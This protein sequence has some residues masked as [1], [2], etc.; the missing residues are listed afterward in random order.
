MDIQIQNNFTPILLLLTGIYFIFLALTTLSVKAK[1]LEKVLES[2]D[3]YI[4]TNEFCKCR[5]IKLGS[6]FHYVI[7]CN[8]CKIKRIINFEKEK[9]IYYLLENIND[10][11]K[12]LI[13]TEGGDTDL[14]NFLPY[15]L[16]QNSI[17]LI[18]FIPQY[19]LSAGSFIALASKK[20]YLNWYSSMGPI[21][22]QIDYANS[23]SDDDDDYDES[24]PAKYIKDV[25]S[26]KNSLTKLKSMEANSYHVDDLFLLNSKIFFII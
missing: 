21:D 11:A 14:A 2:E 6:C 16:C 4:I 1:E 24:F 8:L 12:F 23:T 9:D 17:E 20:I 18:S 13:H 19:A 3:V 10:K 7:K 26:K 15:I 5:H 22:T 25:T